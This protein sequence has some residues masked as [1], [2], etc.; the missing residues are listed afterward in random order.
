MP[1]VSIYNAIGNLNGK[2]VEVKNVSNDTY[3][4]ENGAAYRNSALTSIM[5]TGEHV[6]NF[7]SNDVMS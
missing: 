7:Y 3:L 2:F 4:N 5:I 6:F 1:L